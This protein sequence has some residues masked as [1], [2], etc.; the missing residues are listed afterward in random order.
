VDSQPSLSPLHIE[1]GAPP[2]YSAQASPPP[3]WESGPPAPR[4][5]TVINSSQPVPPSL[6]LAGSS[7]AQ[8]LADRSRTGV[9]VNRSNKP[10]ATSTFQVVTGR[11][12]DQ[13]VILNPGAPSR[14]TARVLPNGVVIGR[15]GVERVS[16]AD[17]QQQIRQHLNAAGK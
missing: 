15:D 4:R 7:S 16:L 17:F 6:S 13:R 5:D 11:T 2:P 8:A 9:I 12:G 14:P 10:P 1:R 3:Y